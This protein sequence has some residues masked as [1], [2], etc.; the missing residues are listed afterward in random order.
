[1]LDRRDFLLGAGC[2]GA[3]AG[4]EA[5]R[6]RRT[7]TLFGPE[8]RLTELVPHRWRGWQ[9]G[10]AGDI[11]IPQSEGSL[12]SQLYSEQLARVYHADAGDGANVMLLIARGGV[13]SDQLQLHR[14]ES[15]YP[16]VGFAITGRRF[17]SIAAE[18][19]P[20]VPAVAL[21]A[22]SGDRTEDILYWTRIGRN[23]PRTTS[24][25]TWGRLGDA[26]HGYR[27]DGVLVRAS[28]LRG[29]TGDQFAA[30]SAFLQ[31]MIAA[32][33]PAAR[34]GLIGR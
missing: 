16:A 1:M 34:L 3:V 5:L 14:P 19:A 32:L 31:G 11:V 27:G 10:G 2:V 12:A 28:A 25:Q 21:T 20:A 15:C 18:G 33:S 30:L 7:L 13:Q 9:E 8:A 23:L 17:V 22:Q 4:A 29:A 6:P 26:L 24:E